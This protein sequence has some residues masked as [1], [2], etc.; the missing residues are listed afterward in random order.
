MSVQTDT[1]ISTSDIQMYKT[2]R[3]FNI[4]ISALAKDAKTDIDKV[5]LIAIPSVVRRQLRRGDQSEAPTLSEIG[6]GQHCDFC[7]VIANRA[8]QPISIDDVVFVNNDPDNV[9]INHGTAVVSNG[10]YFAIGWKRHT[11][12]TILIYRILT[13]EVYLE[14][15][16]SSADKASG[17]VIRPIAKLISELVGHSVASWRGQNTEFPQELAALFTAVEQRLVIDIHTPIYMDVIRMTASSDIGQATAD[18]MQAGGF[19][20]VSDSSVNSFMFEVYN[21]ILDIRERQYA[22]LSDDTRRNVEPLRAV[23]TLQLNREDNEIIVELLF[24]RNDDTNP[25]HFR[26]ILT[27]ENFLD[28]DGRPVLERGLVLRHPTFE[29][30]RVDLDSRKTGVVVVNLASIR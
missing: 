30:L 11:D 9:S 5:R 4:N 20:P 17:K 14:D 7:Q 23:E 25:V 15:S 22:R 10:N 24:P 18:R 2:D 19:G 21:E 12:K 6:G 28:N 13:T 27:P 8:G 26:T 1:T 16:R 29:R 3:G